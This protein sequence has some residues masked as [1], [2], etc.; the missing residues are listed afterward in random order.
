M[1]IG[2]I[3]EERM[4][5]ANSDIILSRT[6]SQVKRTVTTLQNYR[7]TVALHLTVVYFTATF[8]YVVITIFLI[9]GVTLEGASKGI[10]FYIRSQSDISRLADAEV[11]ND[12]MV[13]ISFISVGWGSLITLASYKF[14]HNYYRDTIIVCVLN[15]A[16][17]VFAGFVIFPILGHMAHVQDKLVSEVAESGFGLVFIAYPE[18]FAQLPWV[19]LWSI[20]FFFMVI[21]L[22]V[23]MQFGGLETVMTALQDQ[24]PTFLRS[25]H[26]LLTAGICSL[27]YLLSLLCVTWA[28]IYWLP[29]MDHYVTGWILVITALLQLIG[30]SW[31]LNHEKY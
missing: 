22:G 24:F 15:C 28:G 9:R 8:P 23:D 16:T 7:K 31:S 26:S 19:P 4:E 17:S 6:R 21:T 27:F 30:F 5:M 12:P 1:F 14:H 3:L 29:F 20:L 18:A 25:K 11:W 2:G 10:E 13:Q